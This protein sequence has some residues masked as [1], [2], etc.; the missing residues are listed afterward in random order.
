MKNIKETLRLMSPFIVVLLILIGWLA[1]SG[2]EDYYLS[3]FYLLYVAIIIGGFSIVKYR[4]ND[5]D[6]TDISAFKK[7][8]FV[9]I[10]CAIALFLLTGFFHLFKYLTFGLA[11]IFYLLD[12]LIV[13]YIILLISSMRTQKK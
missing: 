13:V 9:S 5:I 7:E 12:L 8:L 11:L 10:V 4:H 1:T 6:T 3:T 2:A